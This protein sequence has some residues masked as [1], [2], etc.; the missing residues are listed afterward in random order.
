MNA[1]DFALEWQAAWNSHDLDRVLSHYRDDI[2]FRSRKA[3]DLVGSGE[4]HGKE[5]LRK[6]W[7][8]ALSRQP[9]LRFQVLDVYEGHAALVI[10]YVNHKG[11]HAA[12]TLYF[13]NSG[14]VF[15]ASACHRGA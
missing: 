5:A 11:V 12:E 6:Y 15:L 9:D 7:S 1:N 4:L 3:R 10:C 14:A 8:K 13:D 2:V